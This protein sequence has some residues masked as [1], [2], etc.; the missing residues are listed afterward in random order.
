[1][2]RVCADCSAQCNVCTGAAAC[3]SCRSPYVL[4]SGYCG[5][6][7]SGT[8]NNGSTC[9]ECRTA[10]CSSGFYLSPCGPVTDATCIGTPILILILILFV[11]KCYLVLAACSAHCTS[12]SGSGATCTSC[13]APF[14]TSN[15]ICTCPA[16]TW[17][18]GATCQACS[19]SSCTAGQYTIA[20][21]P[22]EDTSCGSCAANTFSSNGAVS[23]CSNCSA[24]CSSIQ[25][26]TP[27]NSTVNSQCHN[28]PVNCQSC[29]SASA[30]SAC[31]SPA[32]L[33]AGNC[34][35]CSA[36]Q[37]ASSGACVECSMSN[38]PGGQRIVPC[39]SR[40]DTS[41]SPCA[42]N[43]FSSANA[44]GCST[45]SSP[46][47]PVATFL[48]ACTPS[49]DASCTGQCSALLLRCSQTPIVDIFSACPASCIACN[50]TA[51]QGCDAEHKLYDST[52]VVS[53]PPGTMTVGST[54]ID[55][56]VGP[57]ST[58]SSHSPSTS[59]SKFPAWAIAIIVILVLVLPRFF[60]ANPPCC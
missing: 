38:C 52:C 48:S 41:C 31:V 55:Q 4:Q 39:T 54:C 10:P 57:S 33:V 19:P 26:S 45:C 1:L 34:I 5:C 21:S 53:C 8:F 42:S 29:S 16:R 3:T 43:Q 13:S 24:S 20:C 17:F 60:V 23:A 40:Q 12:C 14:V 30:C 47:C 58:A 15:G 18:N 50:A 59:S 11:L 2:T 7:A 46:S 6:P 32:V 44:T 51:C 37:F 36:N 28:C 49:M 9:V 27:C 22:T 56:L 35:M 25:Y